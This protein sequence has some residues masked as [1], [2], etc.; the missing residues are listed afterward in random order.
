MLKRPETHRIWRTVFRQLLQHNPLL[1]PRDFCLS[2][3]GSPKKHNFK[4]NE[5]EDMYTGFQN[6]DPAMSYPNTVDEIIPIRGTNLRDSISSKN[7]G[8]PQC[9]RIMKRIQT[10]MTPRKTTRQATPTQ[11]ASK[12]TTFFVAKSRLLPA[13]PWT[14]SDC[15]ISACWTHLR[16]TPC[17]KTLTTEHLTWHDP[18]PIQKNTLTIPAKNILTKTISEKFQRAQN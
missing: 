18:C 7:E 1:D 15:S 16:E 5:A 11:A 10:Q 14:R 2:L 12:S 13:T 4:K 17:L 9:Y 3:W 6:G 8:V